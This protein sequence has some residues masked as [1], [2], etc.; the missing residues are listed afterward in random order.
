MKNKYEV[1]D[2]VAVIFKREVLK[3]VNTEVLVPVKVVNGYFDGQYNMF[4]DRNNNSYLHYVEYTPGNVYGLRRKVVDLK[5]DYNTNDYGEAKKLFFNNLKTFVYSYAVSEDMKPGLL[6]INYDTGKAI[7]VFDDIDLADCVVNDEGIVVVKEDNDLSTNIFD[8]KEMVD[9]IKE[10]VIGQ[11][12]AI[13]KLVTALWINLQSD[14]KDNIIVIGPTGSGKTAIIREVGKK[15]GRF[16]YK[17]SAVGLTEAG[18]KGRN[19]SEMFGDLLTVCGN[20]VNVAKNAI[21]ILDEFDKISTKRGSHI[22]T[23]AIQ[24]ELLTVLEDGEV[25][26]T[27][28]KNSQFEEKI[29]LPTNDITFIGLGNFYSITSKVSKEV[30][31]ERNIY[32]SSRKCDSITDKDL[33]EDGYLPDLIGRMPVIIYLNKLTKYNLIEIMKNSRNSILNDRLKILA[34]NGVLVNV[35][36]ECYE[37]MATVADGMAGARGLNKIV[38]NTLSEIFMN[39][40]LGNLDYN[41]AELGKETVHNPKKYVKKKIN[42]DLD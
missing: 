13:E 1:Y 36:E 5:K 39:V 28:D 40:A 21:V 31:F 14:K 3:D 24:N 11:D 29:I 38:N 8:A 17:T 26:V 33:I 22:T 30:G 25:V 10:T 34:N 12:E 32:K 9:Y 2:E 35:L 7:S 16:V 42:S 15:L 18:Y 41:Y 19:L 4:I 6:G 23:E 37:E 27:V 20:D